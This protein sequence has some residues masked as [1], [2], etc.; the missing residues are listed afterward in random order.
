M[1]KV[2]IPE[3]YYV[4]RRAN[5]LAYITPDGDDAAAKKRKASVDDW[6][7]WARRNDPSGASFFTFVNT[8]QTGFVLL[9]NKT[10][11]ST[12]NQVWRILDPRGFEIEI[13][14]DNMAEILIQSGVTSGKFDDP[15]IYGRDGQKNVLIP[16]G[17][18]LHETAIA[19]AALRHRKTIPAGDVNVGDKVEIR[20]NGAI[21]I[22]TYAGHYHQLQTH[23]NPVDSYWITGPGFRHKEDHER[24]YAYHEN[25]SKVRK[26]FFL[27]ETGGFFDVTK[28]NVVR[29]IEP[30]YNPNA[31]NDVKKAYAGKNCVWNGQTVNTIRRLDM[32][33][34]PLRDAAKD[35]AISRQARGVKNHA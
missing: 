11:W 14:S 20:R 17:S 4:G 27:T 12:S 28:L 6:A 29:V 15:M 7:N 3:Q 13:Y 2:Y 19:N 33:L 34:K 10:R 31:A 16:I 26:H 32:Q 9:A 25:I 22:V 1:S 35:F 8:A 5:R 24:K 30:N 18:P 23:V 21:E